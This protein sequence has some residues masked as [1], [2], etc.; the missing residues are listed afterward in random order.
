MSKLDEALSLQR[1]GK[2]DE[3]E[4]IY[5]EVIK[6]DPVNVVAM[7]FLGVLLI[8]KGN[9]D[10]SKKF[11]EKAAELQPCAPIFENLGLAYYCSQEFDKA[12]QYYK[13]AMGDEFNED[14]TLNIVKCYEA[15][16]QYDEAIKNLLILNQKD[17]E[18][19]EYI[20]KLAGAHSAKG[21]YTKALEYY[22]KSLAK[23]PNDAIGLNN[24]GLVYENL[25]DLKTARQYYEK[26][27]KIKEN[28]EAFYNLGVL[29]RK[30]QK[31]DESIVYLK[32][33]LDIQPSSTQANVS[34]GMSYYTKKD[35]NK[36]M[37]HY[38]QRKPG[39]R[40]K[41]KNHWFSEDKHPDSSILVYFDGGFGDEIMLSRYLRYLKEYFREVNVLV[42]PQLLNLYKLNFPDLKIHNVKEE[43]NYDFAVNMMELPY[44]LKMDFEHI[45]SAPSYFKAD[46]LRKEALKK[47]YFYNFKK[48]VGLCWTGNTDVHKNRAIPLEKLR[49]LLGI[50]NIEFYSFQK[51]D[52]KNQIKSFRQIVDLELDLYDFSDTASALMNVD[53]LITID[54]AV[55]HLAGALGKKTYLMLPYDAEWRWFN[56]TKTTPWYPSVQIFRQTQIGNWDNVVQEIYKC[57]N[58]G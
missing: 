9:L 30:E 42:S 47:K 4:K 19:I 15:L 35:L 29:A 36:G 58:M 8:Q 7:N 37:M 40:A 34:L 14:I 50:E 49:P 13:N 3:A 24:A 21:E 5:L 11:L 25:G 43:V 54:T 27:L 57:L 46:E 23:D 20:R 48:K 41:Y 51:D 33:A 38:A 17:P 44:C 28:Y 53:V 39:V 10:Y 1:E 6:D 52:K 12:L 22:N 32:K 55:A 31:I 26:S 45:P 56:D 2:L 18:N 16:K